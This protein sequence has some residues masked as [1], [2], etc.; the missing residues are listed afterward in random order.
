MKNGDTAKL[1]QPT[2]QGTVAETRWNN[3]KDCKE[4]RLE[5]SDSEGNA[6]DRWFLESELEQVQA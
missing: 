6:H 4:H 5:W 2:I 1:T 3:E